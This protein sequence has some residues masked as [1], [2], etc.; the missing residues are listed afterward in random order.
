MSQ[1]YE[2]DSVNM[3]LDMEPSE[4]EVIQDQ[5]LMDLATI[6]DL[7][8]TEIEIT[9][10]RHH[11]TDV[12]L[13]IPEDRSSLIDLI[14]SRDSELPQALR[15]EI[16]NFRRKYRVMM[17]LSGSPGTRRKTEF[18][19]ELPKR[20]LT[21]LHL[22]DAH[23]E[24][25]HSGKRLDYWAQD[26]VRS[27]FIR[28]MPGLLNAEHLRPDFVFFTG[29]V[30]F[31]GDEDEYAIAS[32]FTNELLDHLPKESETDIYFVPG[33]HDVDRKVVQRFYREEEHASDYLQ[34]NTRVIEYLNA[35]SFSDDR[36]RVFARLANFQKFV[37][38][39]GLNGHPTMNHGYFFTDRK[40]V[41]GVSVGIAGLNSAWRCGS[42]ADRGKLV[43]GVP[44]IDA[45]TKELSDAGV[46][47]AL[48]HHPSESDWFVID[49]L[50]YQRNNITFYDF[51]LRGHEHDPHA[52]AL[53]F[54]QGREYCQIS[55]GALY[56]HDKFQNSFNA[57][58]I[59][60]DTGSAWVF[61][62]RLSERTLEWVKD[63]ELYS[64]GFH[65]F[66]LPD[67]LMERIELS[68]QQV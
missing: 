17:Y 7:A 45:S 21:W 52:R 46:R 53:A 68:G 18:I 56:S 1:D 47:I 27:A 36:E 14:K 2:T 5:F 29:D 9:E 42:D 10:I 22:S 16:A 65:A 26:K 60:L 37:D 39:L 61:F 62:W 8:E 41:D 35:P 32:H 51:V 43:L 20:S 38:A 58:Q 59:D 28:D 12:S 34:T 6:L 50:V 24:A 19:P 33:N 40:E 57:V 30:A 11:C 4:F 13:R 25:P 55:S 67:A 54:H 49:D 48:M 23:F 63:V 44:Q 31:S 3:L 66:E 15:K 64:N